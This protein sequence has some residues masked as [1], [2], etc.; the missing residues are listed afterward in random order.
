MPIDAVVDETR[1]WRVLTDDFE[2]IASHSSR[3]Y[4]HRR[5]F[6]GRPNRISTTDGST[7]PHDGAGPLPRGGD[8]DPWHQ[9]SPHQR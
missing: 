8:C 1:P 5:G 3:Q 7:L 6:E 2:V 9:S 4:S